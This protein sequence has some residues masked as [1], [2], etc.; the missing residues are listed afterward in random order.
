MSRANTKLAAGATVLALGGLAAIAVSQT[1]DAKTTKPAAAAE[2]VR[3]ETIRQTIRVVKREKPRHRRPP[4]HQRTQPATVTRAPSAAPPSPA[5]APVATAGSAPAA[6][7]VHPVAVRHVAAA[8]APPAHHVT[9]RTSGS[10]GSSGG[11]Q[12]HDDGGER[13]HEGGGDD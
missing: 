7:P 3:T 6:A 9:T 13:E 5:P 12:A 10:S 8:P 2:V 11:G 4:R 1:G